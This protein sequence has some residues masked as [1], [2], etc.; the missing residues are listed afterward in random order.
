MNFWRAIAA[1]LLSLVCTLAVSAFVT[2]QTL[3]TTV[4]DRNE[5]KTWLAGSGVYQNLLKIMADSSPAADTTASSSIASKDTVGQALAQTFPTTFVR[6][7]TEK[8]LDG[9]YNWLESTTPTIQFEID[10]TAYKETFVTK[11]SALLEP[12]LAA[13]PRCT[14]FSQFNANNPTCLPPSITAKQAADSIATD[15]AHSTN[16]FTS[17]LTNRTIEQA[18][19]DQ[20]TSS[21]DPNQTQLPRLVSELHRWLFWLPFLALVCG[22]LSVLLS[23]RH[24]KAA[25]HLTG[26]LTFGLAITCAL[27]FVISYVG[28]TMRLSD[29][30]STNNAIVTTIVEPIVHQAAPSIGNRLA[31]ISGIAG[32]I[33][34]ILWIFFRTLRKQKEKTELLTPESPSAP[35]APSNDTA[36]PS[37][38]ETNKPSGS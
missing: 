20:R 5:A 35:Q 6:Q 1:S 16:I 30:T 11:L 23:R 12:Q 13:L 32:V 26:R 27:G 22:V 33:T 7:S 8:V 9:T 17:P 24:L 19:Q 14:T 29:Y 37:K 10:T 2:L 38:P 4:L 18:A 34:L 21:G 36:E 31:L 3:Q 28:Q 15:L 25:S